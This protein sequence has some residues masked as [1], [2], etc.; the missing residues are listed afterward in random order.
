MYRGFS[1]I[2]ATFFVVYVIGMGQYS[3]FTPLSLIEPGT[4]TI[5]VCAFLILAAGILVGS[6]FIAYDKKYLGI[7]GFMIGLFSLVY[8][9]WGLLFLF[10]MPNF[11]GKWKGYFFILGGLIWFLAMGQS[12]SLTYYR[13]NTPHLF[14]PEF[15][16]ISGSI[17]LEIGLII[18]SI[19]LAGDKG[20]SGLVGLFLAL[21]PP[22][23]LFYLTVLPEKNQN[24]TEQFQAVYRMI[25]NTRWGVGALFALINFGVLNA[26]LMRSN[27]PGLVSK[28]LLVLSGACAAVAFAGAL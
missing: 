2:L 18:G 11:S 9:V 12:A 22:V 7:I 14:D 25:S 19:L 23:G 15:L 6:V 20:Y 13:P 28:L 5:D 26:A 10:F 3:L 17:I 27:T 21:L 16:L 4:K 24:A 8:P 1:T